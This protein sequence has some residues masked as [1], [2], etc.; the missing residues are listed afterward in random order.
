LVNIIDEVY[1]VH[2]NIYIFLYNRYYFNYVEA[3]NIYWF[4]VEASDYDKLKQFANRS[5][6]AE[7]K[8]LTVDD[9]DLNQF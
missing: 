8:N 7:I 4:R 3:A 6:N 1:V 2:E 9:I 5:N